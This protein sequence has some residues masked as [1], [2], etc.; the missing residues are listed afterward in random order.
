MSTKT[1]IPVNLPLR[2][3]GTFDYE[4]F[5]RFIIKWMSDRKMKCFESPYKNKESG[6]GM[7]EIESKIKGEVKLDEYQKFT[8]TVKYKAID[9][10]YIDVEI[11]GQKQKRSYGRIWIDFSGEIESDYQNIFG[12][13]PLSTKLGILLNQI[14]KK[15][16]TKNHVEHFRVEL[17]NL[18]NDAKQFFSSETQVE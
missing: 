15:D 9:M 16:T 8:C 17:I 1:N 7:I 3:S 2:F 6:P 4:G 11:N 14:L 10:R 13:T 12:K 5:Y 18:H